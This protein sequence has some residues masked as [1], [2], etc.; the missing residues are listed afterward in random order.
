MA[1]IRSSRAEPHVV[2]HAFGLHSGREAARRI[3][4]EGD[5]GR[6]PAQRNRTVA[7]FRHIGDRERDAF[8]RRPFI[9]W[10]RVATAGAGVGIND[11][12][13]HSVLRQLVVTVVSWPG[14]CKHRFR[15]E[16]L[17]GACQE[18]L[19]PSAQ[20]PVTEALLTIRDLT[21]SIRTRAGTVRIVDRIDLDVGVAEI[22]GIAG[23]SGSGKTLSML[24]LLGLL[25]RH[26]EVRGRAVFDG[27]DLLAISDAEMASR[28]GRA[29]GLVMQD[30]YSSLHPMLSVGA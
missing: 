6:R 15:G 11:L 13:C 25:P 23:E 26:A 5:G 4:A 27:C 29:M 17:W 18:C 14:D 7:R 12:R 20:R 21:V 9:S 3:F 30:P 8:P 22:A 1:H 10:S 16:H 28:R 2:D 24:A 19:G